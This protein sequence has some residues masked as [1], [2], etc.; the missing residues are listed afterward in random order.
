MEPKRKGSKLSRMPA[1]P[2][3]QQGGKR[4]LEEL[5]VNRKVPILPPGYLVHS[6]ISLLTNHTHGIKTVQRAGEMA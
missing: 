1:E 3:I 5:S 6:E 4:I 2:Q